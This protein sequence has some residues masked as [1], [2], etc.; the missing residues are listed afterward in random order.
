[1]T[2]EGRKQGRTYLEAQAGEE[3]DEG[4][5]DSIDSPLGFQRPANASKLKII[6][7]NQIKYYM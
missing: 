7:I 2:K 6:I 1:M 5:A 4:D 3:E